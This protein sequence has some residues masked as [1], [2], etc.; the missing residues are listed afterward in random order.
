MELIY[1]GTTYERHPSKASSRPFH[2]VRGSQAADRH[3]YRGVTYCVDPSAKSTEV[4][5]KLAAFKMIYRGVT[6]YKLIYQGI[7]LPVNRNV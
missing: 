3:T 2:Q 1:R 5:A 4:P 7:T 6:Y